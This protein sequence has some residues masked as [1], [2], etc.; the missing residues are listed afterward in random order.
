MNTPLTAPGP[1]NASPLN[2]LGAVLLVLFVSACSSLP[3]DVSRVPSQAMP[4][5]ETSRVVQ[6]LEPLLAA[7]PGK[8]GFLTL[9]EG[10]QAF[11][12]R[13]RMIAAAENTIDVQYYIWHDDMTGR[14]MIFEAL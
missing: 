2:R 3:K 11:L 7:N 12:V 1:M 5:D 13:L 6:Q 10:E 4:V 14:V 9:N 8:S